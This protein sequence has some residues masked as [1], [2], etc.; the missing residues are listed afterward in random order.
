LAAIKAAVRAA[1]TAALK[2]AL[3][4]YAMS[5]KAPSH[6]ENSICLFDIDLKVP[7]SMYLF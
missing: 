3:A 6:L 4:V 2:T 5:K 7:S 1:S